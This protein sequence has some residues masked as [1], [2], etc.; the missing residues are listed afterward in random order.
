M[1]CLECPGLKKTMFSYRFHQDFQAKSSQL[2]F[3]G[4]CYEWIVNEQGLGPVGDLI[5]SLDTAESGLYD[6]T[7]PNALTHM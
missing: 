3:K 2:Q 1:P 6:F 5:S 4:T 7:T